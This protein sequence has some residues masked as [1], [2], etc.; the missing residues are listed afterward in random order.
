MAPRK[1]R[2][3]YMIRIIT[4]GYHASLSGPTIH[5]DALTNSLHRLRTPD[6][7]MLLLEQRDNKL[8][9]CLGG[10]LEEV[11]QRFSAELMSDLVCVND[12]V[13]HVEQYRGKMLRPTLLLV[14]AMGT[15]DTI[16]LGP[17]REPAIIT[18]T[19]CEMVHMATLVHDDIL[20]EAAM[21]RRG[22]T[23][24]RLRG[25]ET[26]VMLGD[27][28]ISHAYH[29][30]SSL[31]RADISR[32]VAAAT[33]TVCE[34]E[35]LQLSNRQNW[36]LDERTYYEIIRRKTAALCGLCC[37]LPTLIAHDTGQRNGDEQ[38]GKALFGYGEKLGIAFQIVDDLLDLA[39]D[40]P[41]VGKSLGR[42]LAKGKL[43][44]PLI[45]Y[46]SE[47]DELQSRAMLELLDQ[48]SEAAGSDET[49]PQHLYAQV[50]RR[51]QDSDAMG[52]AR[53]TASRLID[54]AS[55]L[56]ERALPEGLARQT[57]LAMA[58]AVVT[59]RF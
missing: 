24:N 51:L 2:P 39:G 30:C 18:A 14:S 49:A 4:F 19:V 5:C 32:A 41:T 35:L 33:N 16:D 58:Q 31:G 13:N 11:G 46:L 48:C 1:G 27:Y 36:R 44:L 20:D 8:A 34:G 59:R 15:A 9:Q 47:A 10:M 21:R 52:Q 56:I 29:L 22:Q 6:V 53:D 43:T 42:D 55:C 17:L 7:C 54:D 57:L 28:L 26:A 25:N 40:E 3:G 23:V 37:E 12:L 50:V 45:R 38:L